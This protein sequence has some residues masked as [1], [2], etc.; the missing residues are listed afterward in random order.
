M[1]IPSRIP[2]LARLAF[3]IFRPLFLF[4]PPRT[5][6]RTELNPKIVKFRGYR[7]EV[8]LMDLCIAVQVI[9]SSKAGPDAKADNDSINGPEI[10]VMVS[11]FNPKQCPTRWVLFGGTCAQG[12]DFLRGKCVEGACMKSVDKAEADSKRPGRAQGSLGVSSAVVRSGRA[13]CSF[14]ALLVANFLN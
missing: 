1:T 7:E 9:P 6:P 2:C 13:C 14:V 3:V 4:Y 8:T 10:S 11:P 12:V 5:T